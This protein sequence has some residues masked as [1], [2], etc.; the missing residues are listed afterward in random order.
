MPVRHWM[1]RYDTG[2]A[3]ID[4]MHEEALT[5]LDVAYDAII[6]RRPGREQAVLISAAVEAFRAHFA[7]E[8]RD[9]A[10][11]GDAAAQ[12]H[13]AAHR[14]FLARLESVRTGIAADGSATTGALDIL[15]GYLTEHVKQFD[16]KLAA[17]LAAPKA[18]AAQAR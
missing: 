16:A 7:D 5:R 2:H 13:S 17:A 6:N 12:A 11:L 14:E 9:L 8:E 4:A 1:K 15:N 18:G 10:R 3:A